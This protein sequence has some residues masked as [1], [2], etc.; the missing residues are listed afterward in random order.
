[1]EKSTSGHSHQ[2]YVDLVATSQLRNNLHNFPICDEYLTQPGKVFALPL[3]Q[4]HKD[5]YNNIKTYEESFKSAL[6]SAAM[7]TQ[8]KNLNTDFQVSFEELSRANCD[9]GGSRTFESDSS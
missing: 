4:A 1:M 5:N 6:K 2:I 7:G 3:E 8:L 9:D